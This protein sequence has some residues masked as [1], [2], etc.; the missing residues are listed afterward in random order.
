VEVWHET[1]EVDLPRVAYSTSSRNVVTGEE[2]RTP[3]VLAFRDLGALRSSLEEAGFEV[4]DVY[5]DWDRSP[6]V[7]DSPEI[8][9]VARCRK[10]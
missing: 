10:S 7:A 9:V 5:G 2:T 8:V 6:V 1:T 4:R 3:N